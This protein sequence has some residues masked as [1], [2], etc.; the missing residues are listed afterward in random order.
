VIEVFHI[1][2]SMWPSLSATLYV[3]KQLFYASHVIVSLEFSD[4]E[5][6]DQGNANQADWRKAA[7]SKSGWV[8]ETNDELIVVYRYWKG[9]IETAVYSRK[10]NEGWTVSDLRTVAFTPGD[11]VRQS[12]VIPNA[13]DWPVTPYAGG[14]EINKS[15]YSFRIKV[16]E[17]IEKEQ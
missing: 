4:A 13:F 10:P 17:Y 14:D 7:G 12:Y 5:L 8:T 16:E 11:T 9:N 6:Y 15:N 3:F 2:G 1:S